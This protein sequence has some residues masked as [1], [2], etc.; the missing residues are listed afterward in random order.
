VDNS[1]A[2][3]TALQPG[4]IRG[5]VIAV[6]PDRREIRVRTDS[7]GDRILSYDAARTRVSYH[8]WDY[9]VDNLE[10]GDVIAYRVPRD[11][12]YVDTIRVYEPVQART[13]PPSGTT[14]P[15]ARSN[16]VEGTV[17]RV[18][19]DL[20]VFDVRTRSGELVTVS[21]PF[22]ASTADIDSFRRLRSGDY[23]RVEG[24]YVNRDNLQ[25]YSF[26]APR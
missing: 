19:Y 1:V 15:L 18:Q 4:E 8:G 24:Q 10:A 16:V 25:L 26:L 9:T 3:D 21:I 5:E 22:R 11:S 23:V 7:G 14:R 20:G 13:T 2:N 6:S 17:E 12:N